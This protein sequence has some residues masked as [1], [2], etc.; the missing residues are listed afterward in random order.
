MYGKSMEMY[1]KIYG[2]VLIIYGKSNYLTKIY[3]NVRK[4]MEMYGNVWKCME[5]YRNV[6]KC[7]EMYGNVWKRGISINRISR[8]FDSCSMDCRL[9][10]CGLIDSAGPPPRPAPPPLRAKPHIAFDLKGSRCISNKNAPTLEEQV[11]QY[12]QHCN[13]TTGPHDTIWNQL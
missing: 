12:A 13:R 1:W 10:D 8:V 4:R 9:F 11:G 3:G 2:D 5:M 7:V 6:W